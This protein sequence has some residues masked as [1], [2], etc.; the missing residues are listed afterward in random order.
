MVRLQGVIGIVLLICVSQS[1]AQ[2]WNNNNEDGYSYRQYRHQGGGAGYPNDVDLNS[3]GVSQ[4]NVQ[5]ICRN[6]KTQDMIIIA[7]EDSPRV[8]EG[9]DT[10]DH[11]PPH[12][13]P[14]DNRQAQHFPNQ[15]Q[16]QYYDDQAQQPNYPSNQ[17]PPNY[18]PPS[19][20]NWPTGVTE[21]PNY[22]PVDDIYQT[23][24]RPLPGF[25]LVATKRPAHVVVTQST[26]TK[27]ND[28]DDDDNGIEIIR[29]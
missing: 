17:V 21:K 18:Y 5:W 28:K 2:F 20:Q 9:G 4:E 1:C 29:G 26:T 8:G 24:R 25:T 23:T 12:Y 16:Q 27:K 10:A 11:Q 13:P 7:A 19:N 14:N 6:P 22:Q 3:V 15:P